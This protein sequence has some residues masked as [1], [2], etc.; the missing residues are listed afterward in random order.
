MSSGTLILHKGARPVERA[1]LE[2][3]DAPPPTESW[4]PTRHSHVLQTVE[5][6]A[7]RTP[8]PCL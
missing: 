5:Q 4:F 6:T 7:S 2:L 8:E 1:E 3:I